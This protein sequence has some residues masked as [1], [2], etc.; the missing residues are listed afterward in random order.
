MSLGIEES[1]WFMCLFVSCSSIHLCVCVCV[2]IEQIKASSAFSFYYMITFNSN[3]SPH[4]LLNTWDSWAWYNPL[5]FWFFFE[6]CLSLLHLRIHEQDSNKSP[7]SACH[8]SEELFVIVKE[9][10]LTL[11]LRLSPS[12]NWA[13]FGLIYIFDKNVSGEWGGSVKS[14][15]T[16]TFASIR[17]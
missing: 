6:S 13:D 8:L 5:F 12:T 3:F 10:F 9:C 2:C 7:I 17:L 4:I 14:F 16:L 1:L 15:Y 11:I